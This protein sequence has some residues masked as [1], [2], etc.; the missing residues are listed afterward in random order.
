MEKYSKYMSIILII[1]F[2]VYIFIH[3]DYIS[4]EREKLETNIDI[5]EEE[6]YKLN[7]KNDYL[8]YQIEELEKKNSYNEELIKILQQQ[9]EDNGLKPNEL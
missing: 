5:L 7:E 8:D 3:N 6:N 1:G 9:L 2:I 4:S